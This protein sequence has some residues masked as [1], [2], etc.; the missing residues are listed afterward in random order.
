[1][2]GNCDDGNN[3][4][5]CAW[6]GGDCCLVKIVK[7]YCTECKCKDCTKQKNCPKKSGHCGDGQYQGD[8]N[9]D[10]SN[11]NCACSW[12]LGDCCGVAVKKAYCTECKC[13]DPNYKP[14]KCG[15]PDF[16]GDGNCDD[17]NNS[18]NC[19]WDKGDCCGVVKKAYCTVCKC[20][21]PGYVPSCGLPDY[22]GDGNCDDENTNAKCNYDGGDCCGHAVKKA[23]C[24]VC[25]CK[26]PNYK[27]SACVKPSLKGDGYCDDENNVKSCGFDGGDCCKGGDKT[28]CTVCQCKKEDPAYKCQGKC[29]DKNYKGV[30]NCDD[31]N[32]NCG[33]DYDGGD[34]CLPK[35]NSIYC[36]DCSC[37]DPKKKNT[38]KGKCGNDLLRGDGYCD[39]ENNVCGC[40]Y[41]GG[42][43][44]NKGGKVIKT[45]CKKCLCI[46]PKPL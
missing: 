14:P 23:Y 33:C 35:V 43:C 29:G 12:D 10:D 27:P 42:D 36:K 28:Y 11:N 6:D 2:G 24:T 1:M 5:G 46:D 30:G 22:K 34:C 40:A 32:N 17:K 25:K 3:N 13:K 4:A 39:D 45:Y 26:D 31:E 16:V 8:G 9:C 7:T 44:C 21:D 20:L 18:K 41:D 15:A 37:R 38:C 19:G